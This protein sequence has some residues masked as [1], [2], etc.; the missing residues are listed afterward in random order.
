LTTKIWGYAVVISCRSTTSAGNKNK[1]PWADLEKN[2][3]GANLIRNACGW[4][5]VV[6]KL[7]HLKHF[8]LNAAVSQILVESTEAWRAKSHFGRGIVP[9]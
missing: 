7:I 1:S 3:W 9:P 6:I 8:T 5:S 2:F 4:C